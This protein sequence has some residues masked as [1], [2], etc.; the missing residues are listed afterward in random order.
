MLQIDITA[1]DLSKNIE[2]KVT[3]FEFQKVSKFDLLKF[4]EEFLKRNPIRDLTELII[5]L[6]DLSR[7]HFSPT[8]SRLPG[9]KFVCTYEDSKAA[10]TTLNYEFPMGQSIIKPFEKGKGQLY[11]Y[12]NACLFSSAMFCQIFRDNPDGR[13][14]TETIPG[15]Y[16]GM[17]QY[18]SLL[19]GFTIAELDKCHDAFKTWVTTN[20]LTAR[21]DKRDKLLKLAAKMSLEGR[22]DGTLRAA[23]SLKQTILLMTSGDFDDKI[24]GY[25]K[26]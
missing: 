22:V 19:N 5:R 13:K 3:D 1:I 9:F 2:T 23:P 12:T 17:T 26:I 25:T 7:F 6:V 24:N 18:F 11:C 14:A 8:V 20:G 16:E 10:K 15:I 21:D 4:A